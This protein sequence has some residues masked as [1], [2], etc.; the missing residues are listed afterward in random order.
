MRGI[1]LT[2][3]L[4]LP[5]LQTPKPFL[6]TQADITILSVNDGQSHL[7][8]DADELLDR[9]N[10]TEDSITVVHLGS[11][12]PPQVT[13]VYGTVPNTIAGSPYMAMSA[14]GR[15]GFVTSRGGGT[16]SGEPERLSMIDLTMLEVVETHPVERP[17]MVALHPN[18]KHVI[19]PVATGFKVFELQD[20]RL[21]ERADNRTEMSPGSFDVSS[22]GDRILAAAGGAMH[23]FSYAD[24]VIEHVSEVVVPDGLP[25]FDGPFSGRISPDGTL[26]LVP[27]GGGSGSKGTLDGVHV[28]DMTSTPPRVRE[29]IPQVADGMESLAFHP[30]GH[31]AVVACLEEF[32]IRAHITYSHLAV[33]DLTTVP[34]QILYYVNTKAIPEGIEFTPEGDKLFVGLTS[35]NHIAAFDVDGFEIRESPFVIRVGHAPSSMALGPRFRP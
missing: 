11:D 32:R 35:A 16:S 8:L 29:V 21:T 18:G 7:R 15:Y 20:G 31:M 17:A 24:G 30:D 14:D 22:R 25:G 33:I 13:T 19:V 26:A 1:L 5:L 28:I 27:N 6:R 34:A 9:V 23:V 4:P 3:L 10:R 12:H 2:L